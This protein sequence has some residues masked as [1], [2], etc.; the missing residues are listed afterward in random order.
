MEHGRGS[1]SPWP[2]VGR[3]DELR[4]IQVAIADGASGV[5]ISGAPGVGKSRLAT[6][7]VADADESGACV[8]W[9]RAT[10]SASEIPFGALSGVFALEDHDP[11]AISSVQDL[12]AALRVVADGRETTIGVDDAHLLDDASATF[13]LQAVER[14]VAAAVVTL[15][16]GEPCSD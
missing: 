4:R 1:V 14:G 13:L 16:T 10:R 9:A 6:H 15:R 5:I 3:E 11:G 8:L 2:L 7:V 12:F